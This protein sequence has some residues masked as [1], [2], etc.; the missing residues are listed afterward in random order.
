M[1]T[2]AAPP[3]GQMRNTG[4]A[5]RSGLLIAGLALGSSLLVLTPLSLAGLRREAMAVRDGPPVRVELVADGM[6]FVPN[7]IRVPAGAVVTV[8]L[9]NQDP[10]GTPHDFQTFRQRRDVRVVAW[11]G[12]RRTTVFTAT[13]KPGRY[14]FICTLRGHSAAGMAGVLVVE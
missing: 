2:E 8:D 14:P 7:E 11:P 9:V 4:R 10:S 1:G 5:R 3:V 13:D 12:E 6:R